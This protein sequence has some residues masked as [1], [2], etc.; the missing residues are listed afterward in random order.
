MNPP[1]SYIAPG[2]VGS[3]TVFNNVSPVS[4]GGDSLGGAIKV[5]SRAAEF[6]KAGQGTLFKGEAGAHYNSNGDG[7]GADLTATL[8]N[9]KASMTYSGSTAQ[10]DN[11]QA[12][13]SFKPAATQT[14]ANT[15]SKT[16]YIAGDEVGSSMYKSDNHALNLALRSEE[17][18]LELKLGVQQIPYQ[19]FPNQR[20]DMTDNHSEQIN[21][22]HQEKFQWGQLDSRLYREHTRHS[23]NY[24]ENKQFWYGDAPG[25]PME[26]EGETLGGIV[27]AEVN[28]AENGTL[29]L[30]GEY[31][32]YRLD[33]WWPASGTGAMMSPNTFWN[34]RNGQRDRYDL[35]AEWEKPWNSQWTSL[36]GVRSANVVM[37]TDDVQGYG[38]MM[39]VT[40][41]NAFNAKDHQRTDHNLDATAS[42]RYTPDQEKTFDFAVAQKTRSPNL[43]ERYA[44]S[45]TTMS[46]AMVNF[47]G[48]GNAY[49]GN[50]DLNPEIARTVSMTADWHDAQKKWGI[51]VTPYYSRVAD[52]IDVK[53][54]GTSGGFVKLQFVNQDATL[55]GLDISAFASLLKSP[56]YGDFTAKSVINYVRGENDSTG[57]D[58]YNIMPLNGKI[59]LEHQRDNWGNALEWQLVDRKSDVSQVRKEMQTAG[60]G[61]INLKSHYDWQQM[62]LSVGVENLLDQY[63]EPPLAGHYVGQGATMSMAA[64]PYGYHVPGPGRAFLA[65]VSFKF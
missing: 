1:L 53:K 50:L 24:L 31:Q 11:Y 21:L 38:S 45:T 35:F 7:Y 55:Y 36:L 3:I 16:S 28:L 4:V 32:R 44:W 41:A 46:M 52:F 25:M 6:A 17:R 56:E 5:D 37:D 51:Q 26:T 61:L 60:Y 65:D 34:I 58:L 40:D 8:A 18:L 43:Y 27:K 10:S 20:M 14:N 29:R 59:A 19:G 48:D 15:G 9:E 54:I 22:H 23:M 57:D 39:Y 30:G 63:Y 42:A 47:S 12:A 62:R 2:N 49:V 64:T 13:R 33:D